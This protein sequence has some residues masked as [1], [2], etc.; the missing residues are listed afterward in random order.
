M[1]AGG[2][3]VLRG[4]RAGAEGVEELGDLAYGGRVEGAGGGRAEKVL[5]PP[6]QVG[7]PVP[8]RRAPLVGEQVHGDRPT[9]ADLAERAVEGHDHVVEEDLGELAAPCMVSMGRTVMPGLSMSTKR[10][11]M[12]LWADSGVPVRVRSTQRSANWARLVQTFWPVT[13]QPS[14]VRTARQDSEAR[15]L[16]VPGSEKP[17]HQVSSPRSS[18]GTMVAASSGVA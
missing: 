3:P 9:L 18:R 15:L 16:P 12:P 4:P 1:F 11:V 6:V 2:Q 7:G 10:A 5:Q 13:R 14:S 17:W 8:E